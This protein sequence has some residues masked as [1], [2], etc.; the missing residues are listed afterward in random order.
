MIDTEEEIEDESEDIDVPAFEGGDWSIQTIWNDVLSLA[1]ERETK[2]RQHIWASEVGKNHFERWLKM[3][4]VKPDLQ[5][6]KRI[7]RKFAAGDFYERLMGYILVVSGILKEDNTRYEI[8]ATEKTLM[9]SCKPDFIAG[10]IP[11]WSKVQKDLE[12]NPMWHFFPK[13]KLIAE[14]LVAQLVEKYPDGLS[15]LVYEIKSVN[16]QLF[17]SKKDYLLEAYPH[18]VMQLHTEMKAS[19]LPEGRLL[20]VSK[21]DLTILEFPLMYD[22]PEREKLWQDDVEK[23][24]HYILNDITPPKPD[25]IVFDKRKSI[26]FQHKKLKYK[27]KGCYTYNWEIERSMYFPTITEGKFESVKDWMN[28]LKPAL[29]EKNDALKEEYKVANN[30]VEK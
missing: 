22:N 29:K 9:V 19:K 17:W 25:E 6:P 26:S 1:D 13:L 8:P 7:L 3:K 2:P 16:S 23:M 10:G 11:D 30:L 18:H 28:S 12:E 4:G 27:V 24:S 5:F 15:D 14:K 21:D 20:Y